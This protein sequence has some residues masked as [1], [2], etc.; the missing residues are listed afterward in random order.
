MNKDYPKFKRG[1]VEQ[2]YKKLKRSERDIIEKYII[3]RQQG[4]STSNGLK[5]IRRYLTHFRYIMQKD[6]DKITLG[7]LTEFLGMLNNSR[8]SKPVRNDLRVLIKNFIKWKF[9]DW[10]VRF[11]NLEL[12][13]L[14]TKF[15]DAKNEEKINP[16]T[17]Y[18]KEDIEKLMKYEG[19]LKWKTFLITQYEAGLRTKEARYLKWESIKFEEELAEITI[20]STKTDKTRIVPVK[21]AAGYLKLL[22]EKQK[23]TGD[24]GEYI[25]HSKKKSDTPIDKATVSSWFRELTT[26]ALGKRGWNY[27]LRHSRA[28][29]LYTLSEEGKIPESTVARFMGHSKSMKDTYLHLNDDKFKEML[30]EQV[31]KFEDIPPEKKKELEEKVEILM[32]RV[33]NLEKE[34]H[35]LLHSPELM[36]KLS[37][38][39]FKE[40]QKKA[41]QHIV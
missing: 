39:F 38:A 19:R 17:V 28:T 16:D 36:N 15:A 7:D 4:I 40:S 14:K 32:K 2:I 21:E 26:S 34:N 20:H 10:T 33:I 6:F 1:E 29:E 41:N 11:Q 3:F 31:Y 18:K 25:F 8:L 24:L 13:G 35:N 27:L 23:N 30:K 5:D 9:K 12:K 37:E 22:K